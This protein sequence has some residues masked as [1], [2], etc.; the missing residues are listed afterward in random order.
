VLDDNAAEEKEKKYPNQAPTT[1]QSS[2]LTFT[3]KRVDSVLHHLVGTDYSNYE[4]PPAAIQ[5]F[6]QETGS[7]QKYPD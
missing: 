3:Q 2:L 5:H 6:L 1:T 4:D 7:M